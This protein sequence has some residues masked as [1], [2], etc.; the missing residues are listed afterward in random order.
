MLIKINGED[1]IKNGVTIDAT[2]E[3]CKQLNSMGIDGIEISGGIAEQGL[4]SIR[5]D[6]P[7]ELMVRGRNIIE[8]LLLNLILNSY[9]KKAVF[10]ESYH[11]SHA[12]E[13]K[14]HV[15]VPVISVGGMRRLKKMEEIIEQG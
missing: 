10:T 2:I 1:H 15:D 13:V 8:R 14:K 9:K 6:I 11:L 5:G 7:K 12:V 4:V 3:V